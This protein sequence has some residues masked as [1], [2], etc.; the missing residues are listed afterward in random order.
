MAIAL[1]LIML[2]LILCCLTCI[3]RRFCT[4]RDDDRRVSMRFAPFHEDEVVVE[5][6]LE[7]GPLNLG[8][9]DIFGVGYHV[10]L[11]L[12]KPNKKKKTLKRRESAQPSSHLSDAR[13][14]DDSHIAFERS[15]SKSTELISE[16]S[17]SV[18]RKSAFERSNS[19]PRK[20][21]RQ[22]NYRPGPSIKRTSKPDT[23]KG[24]VVLVKQ[25]ISDALSFPNDH[26]QS[27]AYRV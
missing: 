2:C 5:E 22:K 26:E 7:L 19:I 12:G 3:I 17:N 14:N 16:R 4:T 18:P 6:E 10:G 1:L 24:S 25:D 20:S 15:D 9:L 23:I 11:E 21:L 27:F 8:P 13:D